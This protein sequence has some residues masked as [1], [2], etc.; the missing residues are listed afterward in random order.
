MIFIAGLLGLARLATKVIEA[1]AT[2]GQI[3]LLDSGAF[4]EGW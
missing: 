4:L 2:Y 1:R 3:L